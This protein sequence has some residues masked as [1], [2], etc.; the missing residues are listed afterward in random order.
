MRQG[1]QGRAGTGTAGG[2]VAAAIQEGGGGR[3][4]SSGQRA[5]VGSRDRAG[6]HW[7]RGGK[8]GRTGGETGVGGGRQ[9]CGRGGGGRDGQDERGRAFQLRTCTA[10]PVGL[11]WLL[12]SALFAGLGLQDAVA[13]G[14]S[15]VPWVRFHEYF[16]AL[17][18]LHEPAGETRPQF[19]V[20]RSTAMRG[21]CDTCRLIAGRGWF[22]A[23]RRGPLGPTALRCAITQS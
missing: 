7:S 10:E 6:R 18:S 2:Q 9:L 21:S 17:S 19:P 5:V 14:M 12:S 11:P 1:Q 16:A 22:Q 20:E 3:F 23:P 13:A 8:W 4:G 15:G